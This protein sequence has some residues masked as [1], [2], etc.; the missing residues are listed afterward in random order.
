MEGCTNC[1]LLMERCQQLEKEVAI[2]KGKLVDES[3]KESCEE[4]IKYM[5]L[6]AGTTYRSSNKETVGHINARLKEG[7]TVKDFI[8]VINFKWQQWSTD[9][10]M[11]QYFRPQ[12]L[13]CNK[14][15][16]Y[17]N[18]ARIK[19]SIRATSYQPG[20]EAFLRN[21]TSVAEIT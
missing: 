3:L 1:I 21:S 5:N 17:L 8:T 11:S 18:A 19:P 16:G 14:F 7:F 9:P 15:E 2:L 13:F 10:K 4:I 6:V 20:I 12:T